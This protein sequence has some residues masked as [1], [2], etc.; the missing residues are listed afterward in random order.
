MQL[1]Q[2][3]NKE[4]VPKDVLLNPFSRYGKR[5]AWEEVQWLA[6]HGRRLLKRAA[7]P[8]VSDSST[9]STSKT[10]DV[11]EVVENPVRDPFKVFNL[12]RK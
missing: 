8:E 2:E 4:S 12:E 10:I 11:P 7:R 9:P 6:A 1:V 3:L 5:I